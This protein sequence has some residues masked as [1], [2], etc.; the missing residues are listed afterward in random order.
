MNGTTG[1]A[2]WRM[3]GPTQTSAT[4]VASAIDPTPPIDSRQPAVARSGRVHCPASGS[5]RP[6]TTI[7]TSIPMRTG[8]RKAPNRAQRPKEEGVLENGGDHRGEERLG[9]RVEGPPSG[10]ACQH[11]A[12]AKLEGARRED[13]GGGRKRHRQLRHDAVDRAAGI[14][15]ELL[16]GLEPAQ[17]KEERGEPDDPDQVEGDPFTAP[18]LASQHRRDGTGP[19]SSP[20][21]E[22]VGAGDGIRTR[23]HLLGRQ[24]HDQLCFTRSG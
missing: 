4:S 2:S 10:E 15:S 14:E 16:G 7:A 17:P 19:G 24:A 21:V 8:C 11:E 1:L 12:G 20:S 3:T 9:V 22:G 5:A 6:A 23:D 18:Q 13:Q